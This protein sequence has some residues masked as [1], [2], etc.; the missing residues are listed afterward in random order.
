MYTMTTL[1][2]LRDLFLTELRKAFAWKTE[3]QHCVKCKIE[4][5]IFIESKY[6]YFF[7]EIFR[8]HSS[9]Y[10]SKNE[11]LSITTQFLCNILPLKSFLLCMVICPY[12]YKNKL[13][14]KPK[15]ATGITSLG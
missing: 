9:G 2:R 8:Y 10:V 11:G 12:A 7:S 13:Y 4:K 14:V 6:H 15:F 1:Q 3:K 5:K